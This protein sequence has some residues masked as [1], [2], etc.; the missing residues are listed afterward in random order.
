MV[1]LKNIQRIIL[2]AGFILL[3]FSLS[4]QSNETIISAFEKSYRQEKS[5]E[6]KKAAETLKKVYSDDSY[7]LNLRI[8][9]LL[10]NAGLFDK[11][12][13]HYQKAVNLRPYAIEA[14]FGLIYPKAAKGK[15]A[16]VENIY[17]KILEIAPKNTIANYRIGL[18][19]YG[20]KNYLKAM[21]HFST[22]VDLYPFDYDALLMSG[23]T[24]YFLGKQRDAEVYFNKALMAKPGDESATEGLSYLK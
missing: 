18:L 12:G 21:N 8:G 16:E 6:Y 19:Y 1:L 13:A 3:S 23:W 7:E 4:A 10:Y 20:Q 2:S 11:S 24:A 9:W 5:G 14:K 22:V 17:K 15:W